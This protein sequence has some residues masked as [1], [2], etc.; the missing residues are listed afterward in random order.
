MIDSR[1]EEVLGLVQLVG[2]R[3]RDLLE[4]LTGV[5]VSAI[6]VSTCSHTIHFDGRNLEWIATRSGCNL[7]DLSEPIVFVS[8]RTL[9][10]SLR[11]LCRSHFC[12]A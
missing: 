2:G 3:G 11:A 12:T 7:P 10:F 4:L 6:P 8:A 5:V 9:L 1:K